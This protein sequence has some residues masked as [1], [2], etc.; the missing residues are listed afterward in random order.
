MNTET[1]IDAQDLR[2]GQ[3]FHVAGVN[4]VYVAE[5]FPRVSNGLCSIRYSIPGE[6]STYRGEFLCRGLSSLF[7][8]G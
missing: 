3:H 8:V 6:F 5:G 7:V 4:T 2:P 1:R